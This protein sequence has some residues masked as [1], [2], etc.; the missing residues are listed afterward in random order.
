MTTQKI[1]FKAGMMVHPSIL[2]VRRKRQVDFYEFEATLLY[3]ASQ[4]TRAT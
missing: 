1:P 3:I 4:I 2:G